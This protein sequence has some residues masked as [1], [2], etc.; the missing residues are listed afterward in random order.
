MGMSEA[1]CLR[2]EELLKP[3]A[4]VDAYDDMLAN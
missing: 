1:G 3:E 2:I 4:D